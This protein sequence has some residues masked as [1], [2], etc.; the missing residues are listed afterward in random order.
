MTIELPSPVNFFAIDRERM[1]MNVGKCASLINDRGPTLRLSF[2]TVCD[3]K[4]ARMVVMHP[5]YIDSLKVQ[6]SS[7]VNR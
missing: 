5:N 7:V 4:K 6:L 1:E 3:Q 2:F